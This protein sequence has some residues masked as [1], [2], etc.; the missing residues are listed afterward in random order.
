[1]QSVARAVD[2]PTRAGQRRAMRLAGEDYRIAFLLVQAV[3]SL[4]LVPCASR[5][6]HETC[7]NCLPEAEC[8]LR[9]L[10]QPDG[11]EKR[12]TPQEPAL[13]STTRITSWR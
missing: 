9:G 3:G 8:R 12:R 4:A 11:P 7:A 5:N 1:M 13:F 6:A 2:T 10:M